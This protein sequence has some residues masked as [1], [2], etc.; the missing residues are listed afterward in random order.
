VSTPGGNTEALITELIEAGTP[1]ALVAKVAM[2]LGRAVAATELL[3]T[4][5]SKD[6]ER[7]RV[8]RNSTETE[9]S[10]EKGSLEV[11][12]ENPLP[13]PSKSIPPYTPQ[14]LEEKREAIA[15]CLRI[16]FPPPFGVSAEQWAA[17]RKQRKKS[18]NDRSYALLTAKLAKLAEDGWPPGEMI[19]LA[20]ERGWETVFAPRTFANERSNNPTAEAVHRILG[21]C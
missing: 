2:E 18:L 6:R 8:P 9:E 12:P 11:S 21:N 7:K 5:R 20:I 1:A 3:E 16:A 19:D 4:R 14:I 15:T 10:A 13:K 17:F